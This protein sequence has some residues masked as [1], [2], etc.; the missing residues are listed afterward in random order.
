MSNEVKIYPYKPKIWLG[1][2]TIIFF[3]WCAHFHLQRAKSNRRGLII[4]H[5]IE[6]SPQDAASLYWV[7]FYVSLL[8]VLAGVAVLIF[9]VTNKRCVALNSTGL[10]APKGGLLSSYVEIP[11]GEIRYVGT[12]KSR[13]ELLLVV[14][15]TAGELSLLKS[16]FPS[17]TAFEELCSILRHRTRVSVAVSPAPTFGAARSVLP[18]KLCGPTNPSTG[19]CTIKPHTA[20][21]VKR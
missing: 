12:Q 10:V 6:I 8:F 5:L 4:N 14:T 1:P 2:V 11:Y 9:S 20:G 16:L 7:L 3:G 21:E 19:R 17:E 18:F 15:H 13:S